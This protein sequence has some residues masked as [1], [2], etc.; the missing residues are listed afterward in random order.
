MLLSL[1]SCVTYKTNESM[2]KKSL[3]A[4]NQ[5]YIGVGML[6]DEL[7]LEIKST[8]TKFNIPDS[9]ATSIALRSTGSI[10]LDLRDCSCLRK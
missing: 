8:L 2:I 9:I 10:L 1:C 4:N 6:E 7:T 3:R 5:S